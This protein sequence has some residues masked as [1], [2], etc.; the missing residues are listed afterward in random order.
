MD[1]LT[2]YPRVTS[3]LQL[4]QRNAVQKMEHE[5]GLLTSVLVVYY[6]NE[7]Y[8]QHPQAHKKRKT[9]FSSCLHLQFMYDEQW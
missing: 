4:R 5:A 7:M 6:G 8:L 2:K 9:D 3:F 1:R